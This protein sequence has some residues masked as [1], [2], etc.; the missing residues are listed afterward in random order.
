VS[1]G[2]QAA[3]EA[4]YSYN[5]FTG[6][7]NRVRGPGLPT[8]DPNAG[9][10]YTYHNDTDLVKWI[11]VKDN[12]G[13]SLVRTTRQFESDPNAGRDLLDYVQ[14]VWRPSGQNVTLSK[15][16]YT[17]D[18]LA[19]RTG[20]TYS[21]AAFNV[22]PD[23][24]IVQTI[25]YNGRNELTSSTRS[26]DLTLARG[27]EYDPIGNRVS[28]TDGDPNNPDAGTA[29]YANSL[30]Q[31]YRAETVT[32][33]SFAGQGFRF[34]ADGNLVER[35]VA[36]DMDC[37]GDVDFADINPFIL[38]ISDPN[39][40]QAQFPNCN[41][42][43][44]DLD[45]DGDVDFDDIDYFGGLFG[46][47]GVRAV[48]TWD[49]ENRLVR[50]E[51]ASPPADGSVMVEFAY[52]YLGRRVQKKVSTR[53]GGQWVLTLHRTYVWSGWLLLMELDGLGGTGVPPVRKYTWGLDLVGLNG[54][55]ASGAPA[56]RLDAG[57]GAPALQGAGGI[58]GLLA[59]SDPN[60]PNDPA[61][62]WG[63]FVYTYD[64]NGNV[65]QLID[66]SHDPNDPN[67]AI[68]A[69]YEYDPYG[70]VTAQSGSY[71]ALNPWRFSTKQWD[72]ETGLGYWGYRY[73]DGSRWIS[74]DPIEERDN[75]H[76]YAFVRSRPANSVDALGKSEC[77]NR[78]K[79]APRESSEREEF[80]LCILQCRKGDI[81]Q[82]TVECI[83]NFGGILGLDIVGC[84]VSC[85]ATG[86]LGAPCMVACGVPGALI[87]LYGTKQCWDWLD[88]EAKSAH[89]A[90]RDCTGEKRCGR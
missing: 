38:A 64:G 28:A 43:N 8:G 67:G 48:Y 17:N 44:G 1:A 3:Y 20:V 86:F 88:G 10:A 70:N 52:D 32:A 49:G 5:A 14:N 29:Y 74:R 72:D 21:G 35:Y 26:N 11:T 42:L 76:L 15:Y 68:V 54:N 60:D 79:F 59:M 24:N 65:G 37:D 41:L 46:A 4:A 75:A 51:P 56:G 71:A 25:G 36:A 31:Y 83:A 77:T 66:W 89:R 57:F 12:T 22:P 47:T 58:G 45:G 87:N 40:Y 62:T 82:K 9:V 90:Y 84:A 78:C 61:D 7:L 53:T 63:D 69:R 18:T 80:C 30:N 33:A 73:Y 55:V 6:R 85:A 50:V 39:A 2:G 81:A 13:T 27:Y 34:D 23:P 16:D 19:R